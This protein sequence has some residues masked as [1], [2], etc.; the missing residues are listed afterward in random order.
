MQGCW[1]TK[2][3]GVHDHDLT[4]RGTSLSSNEIHPIRSIPTSCTSP[5]QS[6]Q[7]PSIASPL[8]LSPDSLFLPALVLM[9]ER[10]ES[11]LPPAQLGIARSGLF[12]QVGDDARDEVS[13]PSWL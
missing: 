6:T 7:H 8:S 11:P 4:P 1:S 2:D 10:F 12:F 9:S 5:L 13:R 3:V